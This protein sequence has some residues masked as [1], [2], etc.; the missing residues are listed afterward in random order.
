MINSSGR[1]GTLNWFCLRS[2]QPIVSAVKIVWNVADHN[3]K[4]T[5]S[6]SCCHLLKAQPLDSIHR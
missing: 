6:S 5:V 3:K 1:R 2:R 4:L